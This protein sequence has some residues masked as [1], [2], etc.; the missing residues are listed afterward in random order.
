MYWRAVQSFTAE[1][2]IT[3]KKIRG[4]Y[5]L[6]KL[7]HAEVDAVVLTHT[8]EIGYIGPSTDH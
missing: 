6:F 3:F 8:N 1:V 2:A 7:Q 5:A 4:L